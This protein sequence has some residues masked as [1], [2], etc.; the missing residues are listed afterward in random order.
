MVEDKITHFL[1]QIDTQDKKNIPTIKS[2]CLD[3]LFQHTI[4]QKYNV[5]V[6]ARYADLHDLFIPS[7]VT[8]PYLAYLGS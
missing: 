7:S 2:M 1:Y 5:P 3:I 6:L 8:T 4:V